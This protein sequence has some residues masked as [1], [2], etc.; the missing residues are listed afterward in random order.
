MWEIT[1]LFFSSGSGLRNSLLT[2]LGGC[3]GVLVYYSF[4]NPYFSQT[5]PDKSSIVFQQISK[6]FG[7]EQLPMNILLGS[8]FLSLAVLLEFIFP[9]RNDS[10]WSPI[11]CGM[12]VG[13]L[14]FF[15]ITLFDKSLGISTGFTVLLAQLCRIKSLEKLFPSL[16]SFQSGISN[17]STLTFVFGVVLGSFL[18]SYS[19]N[20]FPLPAIFGATVWNSF[21]GGFLL[22][23]GARCAGGCTSGQGISGVSHLLVGSFLATI[24]MFAGGILFAVTYALTTNDWHFSAL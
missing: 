23:L 22:L 11:L 18:C 1:F 2:G 13:L 9:E 19:S 24:S 21:F 4:L 3:C 16:K 14:Q 12:G 5:S 8:L 17:L 10:A 20:Q 7:F 15:F 6:L